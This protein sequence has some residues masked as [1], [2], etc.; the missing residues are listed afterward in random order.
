MLTVVRR[1]KKDVLP[2]RITH[3]FSDL[4]ETMGFEPMTPPL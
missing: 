2:F 1:N 3:L 4:V